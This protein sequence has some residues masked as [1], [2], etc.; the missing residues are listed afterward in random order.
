MNGQVKKEELI[1]K[2]L[3][4]VQMTRAGSVVTDMH[5]DGEYAVIQYENGIKKVCIEADSGI[6]ICRDV[7]RCI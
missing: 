1:V 6:A 4:L 2:L 7:L 5:L 3:E